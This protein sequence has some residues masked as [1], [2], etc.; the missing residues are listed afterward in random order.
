MREL[1]QK[2]IPKLDKAIS[3]FESELSSI[4]TGRAHTSMLDGVMV[5]SYGTLQPLK[6][7]A[8]ITVPDGHSLAVTPWD[9]G[10][11]AVVEK[12]IR[13]NQALGLNPMNDGAVVR[14]NVP[15]L[16]EERRREMVKLLG[17]KVEDCRVTMRNA[18]HEVLGEAKRLVQAKEASQDDVKALEQE[19]GKLLDRYQA[20]LEDL[21]AAKTKE[22]M[23]V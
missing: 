10:M 1:A 3:H 12:A 11:L 7:V 5:E 15:A 17:T 20:K 22:L 6:A 4:R 19:L 16:T 9:K 18:R 8:S 13:E 21:E 14:M 2:A 23:A